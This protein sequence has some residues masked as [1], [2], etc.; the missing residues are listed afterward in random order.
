M[1]PSMVSGAPHARGSRSPR[2]IAAP[3]RPVDAST[4]SETK[5]GRVDLAGALTRALARDDDEELVAVAVAASARASSLTA[6]SVAARTSS[7]SASARA[8]LEPSHPRSHH[9]RAEMNRRGVTGGG[10]C[11]GFWSGR[12]D[13]NPRRPPWQAYRRARFERA[14]GHVSISDPPLIPPFR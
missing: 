9:H 8:P 3:K 4:W 11:L 12:R 13:L 14:R 2:S 7:A 6:T 1:A 10:T 5:Q